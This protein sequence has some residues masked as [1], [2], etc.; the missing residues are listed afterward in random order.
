MRQ[1]EIVLVESVSVMKDTRSC[2]KTK[3]CR[4]EEWSILS[5]DPGKEEIRN[6]K[7]NHKS[8]RDMEGVI[9]LKKLLLFSY[10]MFLYISLTGCRVWDLKSNTP[11]EMV[12]FNSLTDEEKDLI[13]VSPKDSKVEKVA[14]SQENISMIN[15]D[16]EKDE[17]YSVTF[18]NTKSEE[19]GNLVVFLDLDKETVV[20]KGVTRD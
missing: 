12:A 16:Y 7:P 6:M 5:N 17:V 4:I 1:N 18:N 15:E 3:S 10:L 9:I 20:G 11:L 2:V 19:T 14:V 13:P 8:N